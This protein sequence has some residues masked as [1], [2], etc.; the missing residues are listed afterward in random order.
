M[1]YARLRPIRSAILLPIRMNAAETRASRAI[2]DWTPLAVVSRSL[3]TAE[4]ETFISEVSTTRTNIAIARRIARRSSPW[5]SAEGTGTAGALTGRVSRPQ[6]GRAS[7]SLDDRFRRARAE[8]PGHDER[9]PHA[10]YLSH[11]PCLEG[12]ARRVVRRR[13][14]GRLRDRAE[15]PFAEVRVEAVEDPV[16]GNAHRTGGVDGGADQPGPHG[17]FVV[18]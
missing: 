18:G 4:I 11:R 6:R 15:T 7:P 10:E 13:A 9:A 8:L 16:E 17:P 3:T 5:D 1:M 2:A 12:T 14:V